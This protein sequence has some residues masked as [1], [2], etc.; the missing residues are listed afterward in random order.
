[1]KNLPQYMSHHDPHSELDYGR[2]WGD[3]CDGKKGWLKANEK[4]IS[5]AWFISAE[6]EKKPTLHISHQGAG[7][8]SN[9]KITGV[10]LTG[11]TP[12]VT[13]KLTNEI[14]TSNPNR[15]SRTIR[16]TGLIF[17]CQPYE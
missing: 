14:K 10:F 8:S 7:I 3:S 13:Y 12:G 5:S 1:M 2:N 4:I 11:G 6:R 17:C 9:K 16:K 15:I